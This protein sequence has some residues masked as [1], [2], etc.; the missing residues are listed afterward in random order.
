MV[1]MPGKVCRER[2]VRLFFF[3]CLLG[4]D[5]DDAVGGTCPIDTGGSRILEDG[6]ALYIV[7]IEVGHALFQGAGTGVVGVLYRETVDDIEGCRHTIH[8]RDAADEV[9]LCVVACHL[10]FEEGGETAEAL[11]LQIG[12]GDLGKR[13]GGAFLA[14][15]LIT[16]DDDL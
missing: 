4:G 1:R 7:D 2:D 11:V 6:D 9:R 16:R 5:D 3:A 15:R 13:T 8:G 14:Q 12:T 10:T